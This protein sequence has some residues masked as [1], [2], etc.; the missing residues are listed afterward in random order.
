MPL[1]HSGKAEIAII[2]GSG[3]YDFSSM[4]NVYEERVQTPYADV[5]GIKIGVIGQKKV[6]FMAR[7]GSAHRLPPHKVN[8][9]ANLWALESLG[10]K[11][12]IALNA[13]GGIDQSMPPSAI[14]I[15]DQIIDYTYGREGTYVDLLSDELNHID[16][17]QPFSENICGVLVN[18]LEGAGIKLCSKAVYGCTQGPRLETAAE[19]NRLERD[20]C[21]IVGMTAMPEAALARELGLDYGMICTVV[22]W[23][24]GR[25]D[26]EI[27]LD[28]IH[29]ILDRARPVLQQALVA[30]I[31]QL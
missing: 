25:S 23:A 31:S 28:H 16:F 21:H 7:H 6:A 5:S 24:A 1:I 10:V 20:G 8:Y 9:R 15:P 26:K 18:V 4:L 17:T 22:N 27:T 30:A 12:V 13:V 29:L 19:I 3:F 14:V 11:K 2:G